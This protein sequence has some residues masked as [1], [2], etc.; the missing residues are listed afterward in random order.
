MSAMTRGNNH[1]HLR[2]LI[3]ES[4]QKKILQTQIQIFPRVL[5]K[6]SST[7]VSG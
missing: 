4:Q 5:D 6:V 3:D 7:F 2:I 1:V